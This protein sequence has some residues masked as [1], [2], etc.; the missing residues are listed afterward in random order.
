MLCFFGAAIDVTDWKR[1]T[2]YLG[3]YIRLGERHPVIK[4]FWEAVEGFSVE[5]RARLLQFCTGTCSVPAQGFKVRRLWARIDEG[6]PGPSLITI[7]LHGCLV[8]Q[9]D[10]DRRFRA[11]TATSGG[12]TFRVSVNPNLS[13]LGHIHA[14]I[15]KSHPRFASVACQQP[16]NQLDFPPLL[17]IHSLTIGVPPS[18]GTGWS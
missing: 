17:S 6:L 5:E 8:R 7:F 2:D 14:S 15:S 11:M 10:H 9:L 12:S 1:H 4:W 3:Q 13:S 18:V 16:V